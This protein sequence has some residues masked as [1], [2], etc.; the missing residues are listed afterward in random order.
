M[1]SHHN[2]NQKQCDKEFEIG[3]RIMRVSNALMGF[4]YLFLW[5]GCEAPRCSREAA[6]SAAAAEPQISIGL[7]LAR[8][9][10]PLPPFFPFPST[11]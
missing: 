10:W 2:E 9:P 8:S 3:T 7:R 1:T 5:E 4:L 11:S 6:K